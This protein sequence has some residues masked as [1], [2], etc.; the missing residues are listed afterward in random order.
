MEKKKCF[1]CGIVKSPDRFYVHKQM[2]DGRLGK[3]IDCSLKDVRDN[4]IK[5][6]D[7][8]DAFDKERYRKNIPRFVKLKYSGMRRRISGLNKHSN[9]VGK[10]LLTKQEFLNWFED[11]KESFMK[12]YRAWEKSGFLRR[13]SPSVDR[14]DNRRGYLVDNMQWLTQS[15]NSKKFNK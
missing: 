5:R 13:L 8:Y 11:T 15:Q 2:G 6:L 7:Y 9:L 3:C 14:V 1:K 10:D 4:R 12:L